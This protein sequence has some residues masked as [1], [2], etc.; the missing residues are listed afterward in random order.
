MKQMLIG[1]SQTVQVAAERSFLA[2]SQEQCGSFQLDGFRHFSPQCLH[3]SHFGIFL[4]KAAKL[5]AAVC[6]GG[7]TAF[8]IAR[9]HIA[10]TFF[11][12][13]FLATKPSRTS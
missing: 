5:L 13:A 11:R 8:R 12:N 6:T 2:H 3:V 10:L 7:R 9:R 4:K 1:L